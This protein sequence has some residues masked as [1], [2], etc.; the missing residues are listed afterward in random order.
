MAESFTLDVQRR[1]VKGKQVKAIRRQGLVPAVIY[2]V[3][4]ETLSVS[5]AYRPLEIALQK[6]GGTHLISVTVDDGSTHNTLVREV[7]RDKVK[8]TIQHV[9][10]MRVDLTKKLRTE[11]PIVLVGTPKLA[12][13]LQVNH[14]MSIIEVQCLPTDI[15]DHIEVDITDLTMQGSRITVADLKPMASVEFIADPHD[16]IVRIDSLASI[17]VAEEEEAPAEVT[18]MPEPEVIEKG[19][20]EEE[21]F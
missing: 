4:G 9:D 2:G 21:E 11:V 14:T 15:P 19:K 3:G 8:R 20:K 10:F 18:A 17:P 13:D 1:T 16:I 5:C 7:Q 6:A 12:S